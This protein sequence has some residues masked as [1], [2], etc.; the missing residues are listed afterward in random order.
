[1]QPPRV[2]IYAAVLALFAVAASPAAAQELC[3]GPRA[4]LAPK[5]GSPGQRL[6]LRVD[7]AEAGRPL[8]LHARDRDRRRWVHRWRLTR[9]ADGC[10]RLTF[11]GRWLRRLD[12]GLWRLTV[13]SRRRPPQ[14]AAAPWVDVSMQR[15]LI[16]PFRR[17]F[18]VLRQ[19]A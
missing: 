18:I 19:S 2:A 11:R 15:K 16:A 10:Q 12:T 9:R 7:G 17:Y 8:Y 5:D 14:P 13:S 4:S 3:P 6:A 1:M